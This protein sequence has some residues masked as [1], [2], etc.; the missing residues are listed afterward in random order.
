MHKAIRQFVLLAAIGFSSSAFGDYV[1]NRIDYIDPA[2]G[3]VAPFTQLWSTNRNAQ[4]VG[5]ASVDG[6]V[7]GFSFVYD[8]A[9]GNF[10][11][12]PQP[13]G[14]DGIT[15]SANAIGIN[16]AGVMTGSTFEPTGARGFILANGVYQFFSHPQWAET[17]PRTIGNPTAAHPQGLVVGY[18]D[19]GLFETMDSTSG[20]V[21]DPATSSFATINDTNSFI[22]I[23]HGQ[24]GAGK[25]TGSAY[26]DGTVRA[27]GTWA[28][29][30]TPTTGADPMRGGTTS[31]FRID[32]KRSY[33]RGINDKNVI[34]AIAREPGTSAPRTYVGTPG[35]FQLI[36]APGT[37]GAQCP[38]GTIPGTFAEHITNP[39]QVIGLLTDDACLNHGFI[40]TPASL[41]TGTTRDGAYKFSVDVVATEPVFISLPVAL[42]YDYKLGKHDPRFDAVRLPL[43][44]GNNKFVLVVGHRAFALNAGQ[45]FDFRAHG[46]KKGVKAFRVACIDPAAGLDPAYVPPFPT[47]LTFVKA[48]KFTGTQQPLASATGEHHEH[49]GRAPGP[50]MT[51]AECR[52]RLLA[53]RDA[54]GPDDDD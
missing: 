26:G 5:F 37:T 47:E 2:T 52:Q 39:G 11:R 53:L 32:G 16:E 4:A 48:G 50:T 13:P 19:D 12:I 43:G 34:A 6:G 22:T 9:S 44:I 35:N 40:A 38:D 25:I 23:A 29:L 54:G 27:F 42:A 51:Q 21:Y 17:N 20:F 14:F 15:S 8:A 33:A 36:N 18:V 31:Y 28:F 24:N 45:V 7:T 10:V 49:H 30:F 46:F 1:F 3:A 41:P